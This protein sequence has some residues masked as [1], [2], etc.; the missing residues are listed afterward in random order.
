MTKTYLPHV[1]SNLN[2]PEKYFNTLPAN[3]I[4]RC[5]YN[6]EVY[7][8]NFFSRLSLL[9]S[10]GSTISELKKFYPYQPIIDKTYKAYN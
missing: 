7:S 1:L 8:S 6:G 9:F 10:I 2:M 5:Y 3:D 4:S